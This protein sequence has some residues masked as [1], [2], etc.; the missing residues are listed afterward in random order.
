[1]TLKETVQK[2]KS[3]LKQGDIE[4]ISKRANYSRKVFETATKK[5]DWNSLTKGE[6]E[7][8]NIA[9]EYLLERKNIK[10]KACEI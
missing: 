7:V 10:Q 6:Q 9:I 3:Q 5:E 8:V 4:A 1:M 2:I